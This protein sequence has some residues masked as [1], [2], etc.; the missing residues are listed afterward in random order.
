MSDAASQL[1]VALVWCDFCEGVIQQ[2]QKDDTSLFQWSFWLF[3]A[4]STRIYL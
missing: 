3:Y 4:H 1:V 2:Q